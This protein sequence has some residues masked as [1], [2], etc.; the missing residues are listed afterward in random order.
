MKARMPKVWNGVAILYGAWIFFRCGDIVTPCDTDRPDSTEDGMD[1]SATFLDW[2]PDKHL[3]WLAGVSAA[4]GPFPLALLK[5]SFHG[6][7]FT[8]G[9]LAFDLPCGLFPAWCCWN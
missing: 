7:H 2:F 5:T 1:C 6:E 4:D 8:P 3:G 9:V